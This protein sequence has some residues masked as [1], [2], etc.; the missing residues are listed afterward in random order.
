MQIAADFV[1]IFLQNVV[2]Q[3]VL[4]MSSVAVSVKNGR[5]LFRLGLLTML[6]C[7]VSSGLTACCRLLIPNQYQKLLFPLCNALIC[8]I[9]C[10]IALLAVHF[11][12]LLKK[13]LFPWICY[14]AFSSAVLGTVL[15]STEYTHDTA[16]A[17]R[18]GFRSG[19][20]YFAVCIMLKMAAPLLFS[21][22]MPQAVRGWKGMLLYSALLSMAAACLFP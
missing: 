20:G 1:L 2:F 6:L 12:G 15:L 21:E 16:V 10:L 8:G 18:Y 13:M 5:G 22:R 9:F 4:G 3:N 11:F 19:V 17:F 7:T 14:A